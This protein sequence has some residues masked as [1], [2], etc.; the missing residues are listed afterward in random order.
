MKKLYRFKI[1]LFAFVFTLAVPLYA[2]AEGVDFNDVQ[3]YGAGVWDYKGEENITFAYIK[4]HITKKY[5]ATDGGNFKIDVTSSLESSNTVSAIIYINGKEGPQNSTTYSN[6]KGTIEF[7][8]LPKG[9]EVWFYI[10]VA[11]YDGIN[12]KFYD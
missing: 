7:N 6:S 12:F 10:S 1:L 2:F 9:A 3:P 11:K 8:N 5:Y 4:Q